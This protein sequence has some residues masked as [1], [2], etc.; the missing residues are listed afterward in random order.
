MVLRCSLRFVLILS[1]LTPACAA[2][3]DDGGGGSPGDGGDAG[4]DDGGDPADGTRL[5]FGMNGHI[6]TMGVNGTGLRRMTTGRHAVTLPAWSPDGRYLTV[7]VEDLC[8]EV[9]IV[10]ADAARVSVG[11]PAVTP[12]AMALRKLDPAPINL[13]AFSA[14]SWRPRG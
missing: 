1:L 2:G 13:C 4:D 14:M 12:A 11:D 9:Y 3:D 8:P 10:P 6:W 7:Q 5:A